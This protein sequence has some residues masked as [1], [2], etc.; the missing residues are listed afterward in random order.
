M[1][2]YITVLRA[3]ASILITNA[4]YNNIYP[5]E[6]IANGGLLGDV[7]F[8]AVSGF[9]LYNIRL[10]FGKW[11]GK[12][13]LRIYP[14]VWIITI[15]YLMLGLYNFNDMNIIQYFIYPTYYHIDIVREPMIRFL[16]MQAMLLG[17]IFRQ[18]NDKY[19][20]IN[21][22]TN[23][24]ILFLCIIIYFG[25]KIIFSKKIIV[26]YQLLNQ[27][28]LFITLYWFF[29]CFSGINIKLE[30]LPT[31][32]KKIINFLAEIT[33]EIYVV[34]YPLIPL[35]D[36]LPFPINWILVTTTILVSAYILHIIS[37]FCI[38]IIEGRINCE[39]TYNRSIEN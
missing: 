5:L 30:N 25:S 28:I 35:F 26:E 10:N 34:Q 2:F 39:N 29:R 3:M 20:N 19:I 15:I 36:K 8:F 14:A 18:K 37:K 9:C 1:I 12:R 31:K 7:I 16:F 4:H 22:K 27:I 13:I 21:K 32:I 23:W 6:I 17:A 11:F 38:R 24:V 33:L